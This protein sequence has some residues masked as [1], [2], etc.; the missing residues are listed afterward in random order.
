ML[1]PVFKTAS[2]PTRRPTVIAEN[3]GKICLQSMTALLSHAG[4][5]LLGYDSTHFIFFATN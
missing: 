5:N 1:S 2:V 3:E 4:F